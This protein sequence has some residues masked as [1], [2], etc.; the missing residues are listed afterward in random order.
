[1]FLRSIN[2]YLLINTSSII[3]IPIPGCDPSLKKIVSANILEL[4]ANYVNE[5]LKIA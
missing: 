2:K 3:K 5:K 1:M 4:V